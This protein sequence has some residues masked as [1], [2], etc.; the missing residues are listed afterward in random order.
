MCTEI[1]VRENNISN[2]KPAMKKIGIRSSALDQHR[3]KKLVKDSVAADV[4]HYN[5]TYPKGPVHRPGA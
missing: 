4:S 2:I 3:W 1:V 5:S